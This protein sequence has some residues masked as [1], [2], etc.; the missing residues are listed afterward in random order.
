MPVTAVITSLVPNFGPVGT[1]VQI[2]GMNFVQGGLHGVVNF[3]GASASTVFSY[4]N[5]TIVVAVPAGA[6]TG[7]LFV[8]FAGGNSNSMTFTVSAPTTPTISSLTPS[9]GG[10][11]ISVVIAGTNFGATQSSST[12]T[13]NGMLAAVTSWS[14]ASIT[15]TVPSMATTGPVIVTVGGVASNSE[16]FTITSPSNGGLSAPLG[17]LLIPCQQFVTQ[18]VLALD[19]TNYNDPS[20]GSFYFYKVE[21]II[22]G[23]TPSCTRQIITYRDL[24]L[25]TITITLSGYDQ[26]ANA[27]VSVSVALSI[28]SS[29]ATGKLFTA[30]PGLSLTAENLQFSITRQPAGGPVSIVK[31]RLEGKVEMTAYA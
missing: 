28:G 29:A 25:A 27:P 2:N 31:V 16:T 17:L 12:V 15:A 23:R 13:F 30:L 21:E 3:T 5:T 26:N 24:G 20:N 6:V 7:P 1:H 22:A 14:S 19:T 8:E 18:E 10:P 11:G 9:S 4:T